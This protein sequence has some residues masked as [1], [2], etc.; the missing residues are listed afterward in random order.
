M[1]LKNWNKLRLL[2]NVN[3]HQLIYNTIDIS[4]VLIVKR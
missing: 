4:N 1:F 2:T 3:Y